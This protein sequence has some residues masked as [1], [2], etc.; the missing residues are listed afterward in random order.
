MVAVSFCWKKI[1]ANVYVIRTYIVHMIL[2]IEGWF[3]L[4]QEHGM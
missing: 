4:A 2:N 3:S 1:F